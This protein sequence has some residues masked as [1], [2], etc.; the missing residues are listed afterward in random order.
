[1]RILRSLRRRVPNLLCG[2]L[3]ANILLIR[4]NTKYRNASA[5][6]IED[7]L[8]EYLE[9]N[10]ARANGFEYVKKFLGKGGPNVDYMSAE[11]IADAK[12]KLDKFAIVGRLED[13]DDF[14]KDFKD[15]FGVNVRMGRKNTSP[16]PRSFVDS[17]ISDEVEERIREL[18]RPDLAIYKYAADN[19]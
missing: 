3:R 6:N 1:M 19:S 11:A 9:T 14:K 15:R 16:K 4:V 10:R 2:I 13:I 5:S 7:D 8:Y 17:A 12:R 18:C